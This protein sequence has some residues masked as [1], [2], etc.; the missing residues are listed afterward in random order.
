MR[1]LGQMRE[2][3]DADNFELISDFI[4]AGDRVAVRFIWRGAGYG[5]ESNIEG[6]GVYTVRK[7]R[8]FA[9]SVCTIA[10]CFA[11]TALFCDSS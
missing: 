3:W 6:T 4:D 11:I 9:P 7:G 8:I 2:A 1:Q 10:R 5:P